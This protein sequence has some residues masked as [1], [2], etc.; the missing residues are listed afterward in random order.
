M[1]RAWSLFPLLLLLISFV[2][3][4][5]SRPD[6]DDS[7]EFNEEDLDRDGFCPS[8]DE[9]DDG[10]LSPGDCDD[11]EASVYPEAEELCD[12][13]DNDCDGQVD[14][15][16]DAD[17]DG[18]VDQFGNGCSA[19]I[20]LDELDC[21]DLIAAINPGAVEQCDG[22]DTD[23][24]GLIDDGLDN[25][26][27]GFQICGGDVDCDDENATVY[28]EAPELCDE[29]DNDCNGDIDDGD[30][31]DFQDL[32]NDGYT[33]CSDD[34]DDLEPASNPGAIE[35]C[36]DLDNDC[37]GE[38]DE[39]LDRDDDGVV[40]PYPDCFQVFEQVDCDDD[41]PLL[42]PGAPEV[43][44]GIDNNCDGFADENLDFDSDG[45]T[46]CSQP[47]GDCDSLN[48][49]I[50]PNAPEICDGVDNNC[51]GQIDESFDNDGDGQSP[52]AGDCNDTDP[53]IYA[54]APE[55]CDFQD[56]DCDTDLG[57]NEFDQDGDGSSEC[58]GDCNENDATVHPAADEVCNTV[59]DDCD[60][61]VPLDEQDDDLDGYISCTP[62]GCEIAL[63][64]DSDD[65]DFWLGW[66]ALDAL[67]LALDD[68][69]VDA[70]GAAWMEDEGHFANSQVLVW[71]TGGRDITQAE[72]VMLEA[73]VQGG[74]GLVVTGPDAVSNPGSGD[75]DDDDDATGDDDDATGDD[76]DATG[77]DDDSTP[78]D[79]DSTPD[80]D[81]STLDDD[82]DDST[83]DDDDAGGDDD[84]VVP[85]DDDSV[86]A[87]DDDDSA[88]AA[89][90]DDS[91][92][93]A[94]DDDSVVVDDD[95]SAVTGDDDDSTVTG[96][97]DDSAVASDDDDSAVVSDDDDSAVVSDDDDSAPGD[98][99]D[100]ATTA[101][102]TSHHTVSG[103]R[104][105]ELIRSLTR[106]AGP[107][108]DLCAVSDASTAMTNGPYGVFNNGLS[109]TAS[110]TNHD[111]VVAD[112]ARGAVRVASVGNRAKILWTETLGGGTVLYWNGNEAL[113]DWGGSA[114]PN[115]VSLL[116]NA[117]HEMNLGCGGTLQGGDCDDNDATLYP[118]T[119]Q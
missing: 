10:G 100:S 9:C 26:S 79:D 103:V 88:V 70:A 75:D 13:L 7:A 82:D 62:G 3:C 77:D 43:C 118:G 53:T 57:P 95:D 16:F 14:E 87:D 46:S 27:D 60:G 72:L 98:D 47:I 109:F 24:N 92:M 63:V 39:D 110:S 34:C 74:G 25:D 41:N 40:G 65:A 48:A 32:D 112:S 51:D 96:D 68:G 15:N 66:S 19:N 80:D 2:G 119:C 116:R 56:N 45:F 38:I 107:Q 94:D 33:L 69:F 49:S 113:G 81:D 93:T 4:T 31:V 50:N 91:A 20:P 73:W 101:S 89:D 83:L 21:A 6:D 61:Q 23:C 97:D 42:Y 115:Q 76:D 104:M 54:G 22:N 106:G 36:D 108:T 64:T 99:D 37:D 59:D 114:D 1:A 52:C 67:G 71:Y 86:V 18:Y 11:S 102:F 85:D 55:L 17:R 8:D 78:D 111:N 5:P 44:D 28:P 30:G 12:G 29:L 90:D 105:A 84:D 117:V 35:G 58:D